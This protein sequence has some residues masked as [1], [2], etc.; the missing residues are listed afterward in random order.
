MGLNA[1]GGRVGFSGRIANC[2]STGPVTGNLNTGGLIGLNGGEVL[3]SFWDIET[4]GWTTSAGGEGETTAEMQ[5]A[6]TFLDAGWDF[7]GESENGPNDVWKIAEGLDYPRL[8]WEPYDGQVTIELG[9]VFPVTVESN[10]S[11]GY[12]WEWIEDPNAIVEQVG[13]TEFIPRET[14]DP[15]IVGAGG[16][17]IFTFQAVSPGQMTLA[18]VYRRSWE[19]GVEPLKTFSLLVTVP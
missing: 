11:T 2:Y 7:V 14:D 3:N 10:P 13:Q 5:I 17:E 12:R 15:F 16:W 1:A 6:G 4:S 9:Q 18:L 19:E 8:A